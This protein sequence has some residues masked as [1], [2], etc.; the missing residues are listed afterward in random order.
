MTQSKWIL[1]LSLREVA[2]LFLMLRSADSPLPI[3]YFYF[4]SHYQF[5]LPYNGV[6][7]RGGA[8]VVLFSAILGSS[9]TSLHVFFFFFF[10]FFFFACVIGLFTCFH[11]FHL[12]FTPRTGVYTRGKNQI[13]FPK[14]NK[15][16]K[17]KKNAF[18]FP[19]ATPSPPSALVPCEMTSLPYFIQ[20]CFL[21]SPLHSV[22]LISGSFFSFF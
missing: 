9:A 10:F 14:K 12:V 11:F 19:K 18:F 1:E 13:I 7:E 22:V 4:P 16:K 21:P 17:K 3:F 2:K 8:I 20:L 6:A 15:N 5:P